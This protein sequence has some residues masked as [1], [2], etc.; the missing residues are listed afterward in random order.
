MIAT[1]IYFLARLIFAVFALILF[2]YFCYLMGIVADYA[3]P[4]KKSDKEKS[5]E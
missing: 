4:N 5:D 1:V 3:N 2:L